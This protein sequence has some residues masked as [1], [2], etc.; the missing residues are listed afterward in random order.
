MQKGYTSLLSSTALR[1]L[2]LSPLE[3]SIEVYN[4]DGMKQ[5]QDCRSEK[6]NKSIIILSNSIT[7]FVWQWL[8]VYRNHMA[9]QYSWY[10]ALKGPSFISTCI[11]KMLLLIGYVDQ[12]IP[13][14]TTFHFISVA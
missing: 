13:I 10:I 12:A 4:L 3:V 1:A 2:L 11:I 6:I 14:K 7:S 5:A 8:E 9:R